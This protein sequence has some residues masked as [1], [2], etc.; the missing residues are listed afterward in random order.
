VEE[1]EDSQRE[2]EREE[3]AVVKEREVK[4]VG[5]RG[6]LPSKES[7]R[8]GAAVFGLR[9][10]RS[11][12]F[13]WLGT[14]RDAASAKDSLGSLAGL[15]DDSS[16]SL[17]T[18]AES[19]RDTVGRALGR[20]ENL[21]CLLIDGRHWMRSPAEFKWISKGVTSSDWTSEGD[22]GVLEEFSLSIAR[23]VCGSDASVRSESSE[24]SSCIRTLLSFRS[25]FSASRLSVF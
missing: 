23:P 14:P 17:Y 1:R 19:D 7:G 21:D 5:T 20:S 24:I 13:F 12:F 8:G 6:V 10:R 4:D 15:G 11:A 9:L 18:F 2:D 3:V 16:V 22:M 25:S